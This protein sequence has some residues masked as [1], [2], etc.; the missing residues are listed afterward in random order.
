[1][2][3]IT[4]QELR[5]IVGEIISPTISLYRKLKN[6][7]HDDVIAEN[8]ASD[9]EIDDF[10]FSNPY[11]DTGL[12]GHLTDPGLLGFSR[13]MANIYGNWKNEFIDKVKLWSESYYWLNSSEL[14]FI[15]APFFEAD[16]KAV[17]TP[18]LAAPSWI[19]SNPSYILIAKR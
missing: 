15:N 3:T 4:A 18:E 1:M 16:E 11:F 10:L 8:E 7:I 6:Q 13:N 12:V 19:R 2:E 17:W 5:N 14:R 9:S